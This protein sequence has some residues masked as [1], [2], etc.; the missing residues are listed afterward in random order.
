MAQSSGTITVAVGERL[1]RAALRDPRRTALVEGSRRFSFEQLDTAA[2]AVAASLAALGAGRGSRIALLFTSR[3]SAIA[4]MFGAARH[5]S[6]YV[7]LDAG[8]PEARLRG[9]LDDCE[10]LAIVTEAALTERA[11]AIAPPGCPLVDAAEA[12]ERGRRRL[13]RRSTRTRRSTS[14]TRR[15]RPVRRK[16][17][18]R[19]IA[20]FSS[21]PTPT[22][23]GSRSARQTGTRSCTRCHST[24]RTWTSTAGS[25]PARRW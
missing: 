22:R 15:G 21:S 16:A 14:T 8:D 17:R 11:R 7:P 9:I 13:G 10:P 12:I 4:S 23:R 20:I 3:I 6:V 24:R 25:S 18:S 1:A 2:D 5:G 19:P